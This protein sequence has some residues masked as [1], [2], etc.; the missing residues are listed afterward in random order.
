MNVV[1]LAGTVWLAHDGQRGIIVDAA[2]KRQLSAL[3]SRIESLEF[4]IPLLFLTHTHYDHAGCAEALQRYTGAKVIV[5]AAEADC[6]RQ[7]YTPVPK[8][9]HAF[10]RVVSDAGHIIVPGQT[11]H[12]NPVTRDIIPVDTKK[13]LSEYGFDAQVLPLGAH[14]AG[15]IG[16]KI[17]EHFFAGDTVFGV[18]GV[19]YPPF[20]DC[21]D[22]IQTAWETIL[23]TQAKYICPGHG[24]MITREQLEKQYHTRYGNRIDT[25]RAPAR[26]SKIYYESKM[27]L[28][29]GTV[30]KAT[31]GRPRHHIN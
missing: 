17:G 23:N 25:G 31:F 16:L 22:E 9:T 29:I 28:R 24:R 13:D 26:K 18:G 10:S 20:A 21:P 27:I 8:G 2:R 19:L 6:L 30:V 5:G 4:A 14:T 7:G 11:E 3:K 1:K 15:S 12:Y